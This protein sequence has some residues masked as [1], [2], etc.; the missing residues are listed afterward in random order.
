M[1][2]LMAEIT[3]YHNRES[4]F[5]LG[6]NRQ[7]FHGMLPYTQDNSGSDITRL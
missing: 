3:D 6:W 2:D 7:T 1:H 5:D 4:G